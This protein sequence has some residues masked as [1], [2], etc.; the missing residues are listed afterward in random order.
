MEEPQRQ[1][2]PLKTAKLAAF[3]V[4]LVYLWNNHRSTRRNSRRKA[5]AQQTHLAG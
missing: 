2:K 4:G 5:P 3:V 1:P